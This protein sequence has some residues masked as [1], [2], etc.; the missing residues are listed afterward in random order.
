MN[1]TMILTFKILK[2]HLI[3]VRMAKIKKIQA[4]VYAG[5][6]VD[7]GLHFSIASEIANLYYLLVFNWSFLRKVEIFLL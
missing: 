3:L 2:Y 6:D 5:E 1:I 7:K 4:T